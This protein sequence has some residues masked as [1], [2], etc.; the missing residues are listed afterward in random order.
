VSPAWEEIHRCN[1]KD[2]NH[3]EEGSL[4]IPSGILDHRYFVKDA[5]QCF[6]AALFDRDGDDDEE[7]EHD[8]DNIIE[9]AEG[10][11]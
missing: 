5:P 11:L 9:E 10:V 1:E 7:E 6:W 2:E 8:A 3:D 4:P